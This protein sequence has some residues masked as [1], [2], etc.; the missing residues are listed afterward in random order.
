MTGTRDIGS[1]SLQYKDFYSNTTVSDYLVL[2]DHCT[3]YD[4]TTNTGKTYVNS[5]TQNLV[6]LHDSVEYSI[7][8]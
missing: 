5:T 8:G 4:N 2:N 6:Y 1:S 3:H 7:A